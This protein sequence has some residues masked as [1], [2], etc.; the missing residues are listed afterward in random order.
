MRENFVIVSVLIYFVLAF[1]T[2]D[3]CFDNISGKN[4]FLIYSWLL[5]GILRMVLSAIQIFDP[6]NQ[7]VRDW[8]KQ[9]VVIFVSVNI[10]FFMLLIFKLKA[11]LIYMED[12]L[13]SE[14]EIEKGL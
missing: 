13:G 3:R 11:L 9:L 2:R 6:E 4:K 10:Y 12:E 5:E 1:R 8:Y 7:A 14:E